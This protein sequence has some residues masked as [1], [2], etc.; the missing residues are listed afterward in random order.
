[1]SKLLGVRKCH[2]CGEIVAKIYQ[3]ESSYAKRFP[4]LNTVDMKFLPNCDLPI[5]RHKANY[6]CKE[7]GPK[8]PDLR[9]LKER[10][11]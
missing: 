9:E 7:C 6:W 2:M 1:M 4:W 8:D 3:S 10:A 11:R 5:T